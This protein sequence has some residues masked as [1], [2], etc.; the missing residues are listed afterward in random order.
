MLAA[1]A[2]PRLVLAGPD[3]HLHQPRRPRPA[4]HR[5][6]RRDARRR[7]RRV[8]LGG[9]PH[10]LRQ[11]HVAQRRRR[12][13]GAKRGHG[14]GVRPAAGGDQPARRLHVPDREPDA[15]AHGLGQ[16]DGRAR[17]P[18]HRRRACAGRGLAAPGRPGGLRRP[19]PAPALGRHEEA[20]R[21]RADA[22]TGPR[23]HP[24]GRALQRARHPD[25][26]ADGERGPRRSGRRR[27]RRCSSSPTTSTRRSR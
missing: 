8:R 14:A 27:R 10:R 5:G 4:L 6:A 26:P 7:G 2:R 16:R 3:L 1:H 19:L 22:G 12:L 15:L 23:H 20:H 13:A 25:P 17:V 18:R 24:D 11:E 21:A 9:R